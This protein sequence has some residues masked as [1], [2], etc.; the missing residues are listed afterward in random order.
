MSVTYA[1]YTAHLKVAETPLLGVP[2]VTNLEHIHTLIAQA[3]LSAST[4]VPASRVYSLTLNLV[5]GT[6]T[7]DLTALTNLAGA[8]LDFTGLKVQLV[9]VK[10]ASSNT[11]AV[12]FTDHAINGYNIFGAADG[13]VTIHPGGFVL[14]GGNDQLDDVAAAD[15]QIV[16]TSGD[17]DAVAQIVLVA[18]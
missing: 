14:Y 2:Q 18:G 17:A 1:Q 16:A 11:A 3:T 9:M 7:I 5:A 13:S 4:T 12:V 8:A 15:K 6:Q 10:A